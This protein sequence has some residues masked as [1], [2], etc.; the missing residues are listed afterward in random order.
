MSSV[1]GMRA[2]RRRDLAVVA[3]L[4]GLSAAAWVAAVRLA[5]PDMRVGLLTGHRP[6]ASM[7]MGS[8]MS[9]PMGSG[10]SMPTS[11]AAPWL[12]LWTWTV[13]MTAMMLPAVSPVV[14]LFDQRVRRGRSWW[15]TASFAG[16][17]LVVWAAIGALAYG[18]LLALQRWAPVG[19]RAAVRVGAVLL[20]AAGWYQ[21]SP[22]KHVC[23]RHCRSPLAFLVEH[24]QRLTQGGFGPARVGLV[25]GLYCLG[26]CWALMLVLL[27][28]GMMSLVWMAVF[29]VVILLEKTARHGPLVSHVLGVAFVAVG[30]VLVA[31]PQALPVLS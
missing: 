26:C 9:M 25:H 17:Y 22:L 19:E 1:A 10:M 30:L 8:G 31:A 13:M 4:L 24:G 29:A 3:V 18:V 15:L 20:V 21:L 27:L 16:S 11:P 14:V 12:F 23:L 5:R 7:P 6:M 2:W 28:L